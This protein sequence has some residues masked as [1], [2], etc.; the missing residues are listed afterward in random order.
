MS[1]NPVRTGHR[2]A[3]TAA[4]RCRIPVGGMKRAG[5]LVVDIA[6]RYIMDKPLR[7]AR[8]VVT[9]VLIILVSH[10]NNRIAVLFG[11]AGEAGMG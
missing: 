1:N 10:R 7:D 6:G 9:V 11:T 8:V 4:C 3:R 5:G 2:V